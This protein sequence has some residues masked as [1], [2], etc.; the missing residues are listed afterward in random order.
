MNKKG[1][2]EKIL[3]DREEGG[4]SDG[5]RGDCPGPFLLVFHCNHSSPKMHDC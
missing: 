2:K 3:K 5:I 4:G 1:K